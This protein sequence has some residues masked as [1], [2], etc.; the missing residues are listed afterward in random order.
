[1]A[2]TRAEYG[3]R[4]KILLGRLDVIYTSPK[5]HRF[6][7]SETPASQVSQQIQYAMLLGCAVHWNASRGYVCSQAELADPELCF[8]AICLPHSRTLSTGTLPQQH[9]YTHLT[10][11]SQSTNDSSSI[12]LR[13]CQSP[14]SCWSVLH[15]VLTQTRKLVALMLMSNAVWCILTCTKP[16]TVN[17]RHQVRIVSHKSWMCSAEN[18][19]SK[20]TIRIKWKHCSH[21][22]LTRLFSELATFVSHTVGYLKNGI[23]RYSE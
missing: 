13:Q 12:R 6:A 1:M 7:G 5:M 16:S 11:S 4:L 22:P 23:K 8:R 20:I 15:I 3:I 18:C 14:S 9:N 10:I 21:K 17:W 2:W 19:S